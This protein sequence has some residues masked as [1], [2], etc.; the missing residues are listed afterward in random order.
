MLDQP[1][2]LT[3]DAREHRYYVDGQ[4]VPSVTQIIDAAGLIDHTWHNDEARARGQRVAVATALDDNGELDLA[5][6]P[7]ED[8]GYINAWRS[9]R[10]DSKCAIKAIEHQVVGPNNQY[11]GRIDRIGSVGDCPCSIIDIKTGQPERWHGIQIGAYQ[12]AY[13]MTIGKC[14]AGLV[15]LNDNGTYR[16]RWLA[17]W[18]DAENTWNA[19]L[20]LWH[21]KARNG[22]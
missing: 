19:A 17:D 4:E 5:K 18:R 16:L 1:Q 2:N 20:V 14:D 21:W 12:H 3:F 8:C 6:V 11:A 13:T 7:T 22:R 15:Y 10:A 9:F